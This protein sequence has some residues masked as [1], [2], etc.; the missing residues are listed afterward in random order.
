MPSPM[1]PCLYRRVDALIILFV[2]DLRVAATPSVLRDIHASLFKEYK[3]TTSDGT[4]F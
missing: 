4:R 3:I 2:D 1:D